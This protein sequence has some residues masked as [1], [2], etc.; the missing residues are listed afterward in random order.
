M[1]SDKL[2]PISVQLYSV[3]EQS[4]K[5][6]DL[7]LDLISK[8]GFAGVEP[9]NLFGKSPRDFK[10]QVNDLGMEVSS[11]HFPWATRTMEIG[12]LSEIIQELGLARAPGGLAPQ[13]VR[14]IISINKTIDDL[15]SLMS[16]LERYGLPLFLHNHHWEF[17]LVDGRPAYHYIQDA[18]PKLQFQID[19]YWAAN[20]GKNNPVEEIERV[21]SRTPLAHI[22]D[23][24][25]LPEKAH[26]AVGAGDMD[27]KA[28]FDAFDADIFEGAVVE[29]DYC[30]TDM[31]TALARSYRY[32]IRENLARGNV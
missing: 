1:S 3:R 13:N 26:V 16:E 11:T 30:D 12:K 8:I 24:P 32:L 31:M 23:G 17:E 5:N 2:P 20:F 15:G 9:F 19:T 27:F 21:K 6:F 25:L 22:K 14:D 10:K 4:E 18:L 28:I 7:V 29:L